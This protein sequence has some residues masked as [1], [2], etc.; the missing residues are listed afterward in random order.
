MDRQSGIVR[1]DNCIRYFRGRDDGK[2]LHNS[3]RI[4]FSDLGDQ[5]GTHTRSCTTSERVS[6]LETLE[7]V[8]S[9]SFFS[10]NIEYGV[11]EFSTFSVVTLG[12]VVTS[13]GLTENEVVWS[14][15]LSEWSG[16]DGIHGS[17]F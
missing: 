17:W 15:E 5:K 9:F 1:F 8:A 2:G 6:D 3:V 11:D 13:S 16:S 14:E 7:A 10:D 12:P 4:F